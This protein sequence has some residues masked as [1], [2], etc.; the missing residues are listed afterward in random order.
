M[1]KVQTRKCD[2]IDCTNQGRGVHS[3]TIM[4]PDGVLNVDLC[5]EH[6]RPLAEFRKTVPKTVFTKVRPGANRRLATGFRVMTMEE[7]EASLP[8][9]DA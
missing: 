5:S 2:A 9:D 3:Y 8:K 7:I 4:Y 1:T 6:A